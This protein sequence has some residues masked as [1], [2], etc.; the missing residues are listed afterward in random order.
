MKPILIIGGYGTF[1]SQVASALASRGLPVVVAGRDR[2]RAEEFART[3]GAD[4]RGTSL[5]LRQRESISA[6]LREQPVVVNCAGPFRHFDP[7]LLEACLDQECH[8]ADIADDRH[9]CG[10][11]RR[12]GE[13]FAAKS[14][15]AVYGCSSLPGISGALG[16]KLQD[17]RKPRDGS[18]WACR[19]T[20][21][22]GNDNPKGL[23]AVSSLVEGLG[24]PIEAP[25]G[26]LRC[27]HD[28]EVVPLPPPFGRRVVF[29]FDSPEYDL[30]P[31]LLGVRNVRV[32][33]GFELTVGSYIMH[34]LA[35]FGLNYRAW[36]AKWITRSGQFLRG[37]GCAGGAV[38]TELFSSDG[39]T[40]RATMLSHTEGQRMAAWP[41]VLTAEALA[42]SQPNRVGACTAYEFLGAEPML[43]QMTGAGFE[44]HYSN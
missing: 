18:P 14:L 43:M 2:R 4:H 22:I 35:R 42:K 17:S 13:R 19:V 29:N 31:S 40:S 27:F 33:V 38:M 12:F 10:L 25:Q 44:L 28:R 6:A 15:A 5:D 37:W 26:T 8:Y 11:V 39:T 34:L 20:L 21:F 9:Y 30:F 41:C 1:G 16:L 3:L 24:K 23:A 36:H 32:K 7:A